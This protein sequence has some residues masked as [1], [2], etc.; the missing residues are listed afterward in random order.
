MRFRHQVKEIFG[1]SGKLQENQAKLKKKNSGHT[2]HDAFVNYKKS[3]MPYRE[4][5]CS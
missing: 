1:F 3:T 4:I 5:N 2:K